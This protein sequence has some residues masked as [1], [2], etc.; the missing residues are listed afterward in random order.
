MYC[1]FKNCSR[2]PD[3]GNDLGLSKLLAQTLEQ[4]L[5]APTA[6]GLKRPKNGPDLALIAFF[7]WKCVPFFCA[8]TRA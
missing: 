6:E 1:A 5:I 3:F 8:H 2:I 4:V 7:G